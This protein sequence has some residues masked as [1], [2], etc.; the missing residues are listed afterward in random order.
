MRELEEG[1]RRRERGEM[2]EGMKEGGGRNNK[3]REHKEEAE[4][5]RGRQRMGYMRRERQR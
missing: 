3:R 1:E 5:E 2:V 4:K